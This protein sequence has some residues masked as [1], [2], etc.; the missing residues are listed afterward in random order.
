MARQEI[1]GRF[2]M[3]LRGNVLAFYGD[4]E[5]ESQSESNVRV[6]TLHIGPFIVGFSSGRRPK[7]IPDDQ[8]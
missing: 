3:W 6:R 1:S 7:T 8:V 4:T 2:K 5:L